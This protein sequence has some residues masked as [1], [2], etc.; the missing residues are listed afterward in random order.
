MSDI[1]MAGSGWKAFNNVGFIYCPRKSRWLRDDQKSGSVVAFFVVPF[2]VQKCGESR[3]I[4]GNNIIGYLQLVLCGVE[5]G[6]VDRKKGER[7]CHTPC[8]M[9]QVGVRGFTQ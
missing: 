8:D 5:T 2:S 3:S 6:N 7:P 1:R 4:R 9:R